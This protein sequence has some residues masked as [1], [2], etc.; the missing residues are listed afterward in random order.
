[1]GSPSPPDR[2][3]LFVVAR[4]LERLWREGEPMVKTRLQVA[5][6]VNYDVFAKYLAWFQSR[7]LVNLESDADGRDRVAITEKGKR[8]Y[9]QLVEWINEFVRGERMDGPLWR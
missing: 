2:P 7:G 3:D 9:R 6:N 1:M 5:A 4:F 8:A